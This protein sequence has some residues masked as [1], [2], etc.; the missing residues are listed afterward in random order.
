MQGDKHLPIGYIIGSHYKIMRI[1]EQDEAG[2][3]YLVRDIRESAENR[4][5]MFVP[6]TEYKEPTVELPKELKKPKEKKPKKKFLFL[7]ML[8][9]S[10]VILL[11]LGAYAYKIMKDEKEKP[12]KVTPTVV[13]KTS[14]HHPPLT[15]RDKAEIPIEKKVEE[16]AKVETPV[17]K[18]VN[19]PNYSEYI[20]EDE[21]EVL[22]ET[23]VPKHK[24]EEPYVVEAEP[25]TSS[26]PIP[27]VTPRISLGTRIGGDDDVLDEF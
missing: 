14:I 17:K 4:K 7:K 25:T 26:I 18:E 23:S 20:S 21:L 13:V 24:V 27:R 9:V 6:K 19:S 11:G 5:E 2:V 16:K 8:I 22:E 12:V 1:L 15:N 3:L 10:M